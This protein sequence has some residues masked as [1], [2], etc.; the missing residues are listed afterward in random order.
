MRARISLLGRA[1]SD[2][3]SPWLDGKFAGKLWVTKF[4]GKMIGVRLLGL[5]TLMIGPRAITR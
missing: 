1:E 2:E 4:F 3:N 5:A